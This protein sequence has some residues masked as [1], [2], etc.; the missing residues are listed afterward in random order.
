MRR[1]VGFEDLG[2]FV[3][4]E[5]LGDQTMANLETS[6]ESPSAASNV[7]KSPC[8]LVLVFKYFVPAHDLGAGAGGEPLPSAFLARGAPGPWGHGPPGPVGPQVPGAMGPPGPW[9]P[10]AGEVKMGAG[11]VDR[12]GSCCDNFSKRISIRR[13]ITFNIANLMSRDLL[14]KES[15]KASPRKWPSL[16]RYASARCCLI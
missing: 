1:F 7:T 15:M 3:A 16:L 13:F 6:N 8:L 4:A 14:P 10:S 11:I 12:L 2:G 5:V 9:G